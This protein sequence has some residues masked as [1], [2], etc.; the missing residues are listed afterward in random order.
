[1]APA[2]GG[3]ILPPGVPRAVPSAGHADVAGVIGA[4]HSQRSGTATTRWSAFNVTIVAS[5]VGLRCPDHARRGHGPFL[6]LLNQGPSSD[7]G[8]SDQLAR[9][10]NAWPRCT[11][12]KRT[13]PERQAKTIGGHGSSRADGR[14]KPHRCLSRTNGWNSGE[15]IRNEINAIHAALVAQQQRA[16]SV[17]R[18]IHSP[19]PE[20]PI[21]SE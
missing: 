6:L 20:R 1:M 16:N 10:W 18:C 19:G 17:S 13:R 3:L 8:W 14:D 15:T 4:A 11:D 5:M 9:C 21:P 2:E 7:A 12:C